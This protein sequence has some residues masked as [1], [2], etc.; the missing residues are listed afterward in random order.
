MGRQSGGGVCCG[1][2]CLQLQLHHHHRHCRRRVSGP[3]KREDR[4]SYEN[5]Q[6]TAPRVYR[7]WGY[8]FSFP[9]FF[10]FFF[11]LR[12]PSFSSF[13]GSYSPPWFS[14]H[15]GSKAPVNVKRGGNKSPRKGGRSTFLALSDHSGVSRRRLKIDSSKFNFDQHLFQVQFRPTF[16]DLPAS[17]DQTRLFR[18]PFESQSINQRRAQTRQKAN[19]GNRSGP[20]Y[21][22]E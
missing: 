12:S 7:P 15:L 10:D 9:P 14:C 4:D 11:F 5:S 22:V 20:H 18:S 21:D 6:S 16:G 1:W 2:W 13:F 3:S 8:R 19:D 17:S